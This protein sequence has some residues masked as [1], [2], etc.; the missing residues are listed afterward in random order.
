MFF[1]NPLLLLPIDPISRGLRQINRKVDQLPAALITDRPDF[2]GIETHVMMSLNQI[3]HI[4]DR[5][6]FKGIET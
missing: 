1:R 2:K 6:D 5:P 3:L 4:T